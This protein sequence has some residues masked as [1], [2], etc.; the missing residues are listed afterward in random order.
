MV[1]EFRMSSC[2]QSPLKSLR[3]GVTM[4]TIGAQNKKLQLVKD[5]IRSLWLCV[6]VRVCVC[7]CVCVRVCMGGK[8]G[9]GYGED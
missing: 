6:C 3:K 1:P 8:E 7:V 2:I 9:K 5:R 4:G